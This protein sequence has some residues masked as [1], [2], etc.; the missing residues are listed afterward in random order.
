MSFADPQVVTVSGTPYT[1]PRV[2]SD[3]RKGEWSNPEGTLKLS[4]SHALQKRNRR[5]IRI[6]ASKNAADPFQPTTNVPYNMAMY[7]VVDTPKFGFT[8]AE[9]KAYVDA[10]TAYLTASTGAKVTQLLNGE[11]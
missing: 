3:A 8:Q 1:L 6:D 9:V 10:L 4:V 5:V 7:L 2:L 11:S